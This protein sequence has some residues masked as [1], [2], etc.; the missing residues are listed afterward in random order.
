MRPPFV[1]HAGIPP[2]IN[3]NLDRIH[4]QMAAWDAAQPLL[5]RFRNEKVLF[6]EI[7]GTVRDA[8]IAEYIGEF[9]ISKDLDFLVD[10]RR[11]PVNLFRFF[12]GLPGTVTT[13]RHGNPKW[14]FEGGEM[15]ILS[16][17]RD[18]YN[19]L[20]DRLF[21]ADINIGM[22]LHYQDGTFFWNDAAIRGIKSKTI[23]I[24]PENVVFPASS[25]IKALHLEER[26]GFRIGEETE[27]YIRTAVPQVLP[28]MMERY[29]FASV[30]LAA[31]RNA[32]FCRLVEQPPSY[33]QERLDNTRQ[34]F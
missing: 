15:D 5:E 32:R 14:R 10:D 3:E 30:E 28:A 4:S 24:Y 18:Q 19:S 12:D 29:L 27:A 6:Y 1:L 16:Q 2:R 25:I 8:F 23:E 33:L 34:S 20:R 21:G 17:D 7:G 22:F 13:N 31:E 26:L 9:R 11:R